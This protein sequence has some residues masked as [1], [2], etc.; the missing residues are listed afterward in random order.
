MVEIMP[1]SKQ[2]LTIYITNKDK[3]TIKNRS[4]EVGRNMS[5]YIAELIMWDKRFSLVEHAREGTLEVRD[6]EEEYLFKELK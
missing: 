6:H 4:S 1:A 3:M 2:R 5:D